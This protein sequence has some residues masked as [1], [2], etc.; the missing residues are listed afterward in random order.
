[1]NE[2]LVNQVYQCDNLYLLKE[3]P[4]KCIDLIYGDVLFGTGKDFKEFKDLKPV[5]L[6]ILEFYTP[7]LIEMHRVLKPTGLL[8]FHCD[9]IISHWIRIL[10]DGIFGDHNFRNEIIWYYNSAPRKKKDFGKRHD[11]ILRYTKTENYYFNPDSK[12]VRQPY[13][14]TAPRGYDKEKYYDQRG[15]ILDDVWTISILGQNDKTERTGYPTQKPKSLLYPIIDSS[16]PSDGVFFDPF[17]GSGTSVV[18]A[19]ELNIDF[20]G[21]DI[22]H[23]AISYTIERLKN[24]NC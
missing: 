7:R 16:C 18:V 8:Y 19:K 3:L 1:M 4:S 23:N 13:S 20:I 9:S 17:V 24:V 5:R 21:C 10:I 12:Y 6:D 22:N 2:I 14:E 15:K 11:T